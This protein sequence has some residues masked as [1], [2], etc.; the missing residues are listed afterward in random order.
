MHCDKFLQ[1]SWSSLVT[2]VGQETLQC[3]SSTVKFA[4]LETALS[5]NE[6]WGWS[7]LWQSV[8]WKTVSVLEAIL[9]KCAWW[10]GGEASCWHSPGHH[11]H[12]GVPGLGHSPELIKC[13]IFRTRWICSSYGV[14]RRERRE[15]F[16]SLRVR[17]LSKS[18]PVSIVRP[19]CGPAL[20][21]GPSSCWWSSVVIQFFLWWRT[22]HFVTFSR[23]FSLFSIFNPPPPDLALSSTILPRLPPNL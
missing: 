1:I 18:P 16:P 14:R 21:L 13:R 8:C 2:W 23:S 11:N 3:A 17:F 10:E 9:E 4:F 6:A 22:K 20:G 19:N 12:W 15:H 5:L 7:L